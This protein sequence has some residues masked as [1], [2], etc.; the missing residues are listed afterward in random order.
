MYKALP[1][2]FNEINRPITFRE[3][4]HEAERK[5]GFNSPKHRG[6]VICLVE[7][8]GEDYFIVEASNGRTVAVSVIKQSWWFGHED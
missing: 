1:D 3:A 8:E 2:S 4:T 6:V 5:A 7:N